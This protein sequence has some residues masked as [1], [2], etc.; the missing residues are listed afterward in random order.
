MIKVGLPK[1][2]MARLSQKIGSAL[3]AEI[4]S[5]ALRYKTKLDDC[6]IGIYLLKAPDIARL[7][8]IGSL[9]IGLTG[10][11][12]LLENGVSP[13][14]WYVEAGSYIASVCLLMADDDGRS[15]D[16]VR[17]VATPY[18]NL[19][20]TLLGTALSCARI[21]TVSGSSEALVPDV[22]DACLDLVE[23]GD[24]ALSNGLL[25]R[26]VFQRVTTHVARSDR[27]D[28]DVLGPVLKIIASATEGWS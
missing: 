13:D 27:A 9:D 14:C 6:S 15:S 10:D 28:P 7:V 26:K 25:V 18:P 17:S 12:W 8:K 1:G 3:G 19:A 5:P 2:R 16:M 22:C 20:R 4:K 11:E 23:T 24:T 21:M